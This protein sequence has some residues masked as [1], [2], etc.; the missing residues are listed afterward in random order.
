MWKTRYRNIYKTSNPNLIITAVQC[1]PNIVYTLDKAI[2]YYKVKE[3]QQDPTYLEIE[4]LYNVHDSGRDFIPLYFEDDCPKLGRLKDLG[5]GWF[6]CIGY[7]S[8]HLEIGEY[9]RKLNLPNQAVYR[10]LMQYS[11]QKLQ[12]LHSIYLFENCVRQYVCQHFEN[13][14]EFQNKKLFKAM[15]NS[16]LRMLY[17]VLERE[18]KYEVCWE[19]VSEM[20]NRDIYEFIFNEFD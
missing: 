10:T 14:T 5:K 9:S 13:A 16:K 18:L 12:G 19:F 8:P 3:L 1:F 6:W 2:S 7:R 4:A 15:S 11:F 17:N 20:Y